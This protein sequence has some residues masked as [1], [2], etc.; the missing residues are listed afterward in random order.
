MAIS[1]Y[2]LDGDLIAEQNDAQ[3]GEPEILSSLALP[4]AGTYEIRV[5][6]PGNA[7]GQYAILVY[8]EGSYPFIF[9]G[10]LAYGGSQNAAL[11]VESDHFWH[12][13]GQSGDVVTVNV[14]QSDNSDLILRLYGPDGLSLIEYSNKSPAGIPERLL[15]YSLPDSGLYSVVVG[16]FN[17]GRAVY[18]IIITKG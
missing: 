15:N 9:Q 8:D 7:S 4:S 5:H 2:D 1:F 3:N 11:D 6:S 13:V 18:Q 12:F 14:D 17:F 10:T 16:E